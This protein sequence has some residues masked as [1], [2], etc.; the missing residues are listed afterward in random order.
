MPMAQVEEGWDTAVLHG[1]SW[2]K[3]EWLNLWQ[4]QGNCRF[5]GERP[6]KRP[7]SQRV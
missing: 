3:R 1:L 2:L 7:L 4:K 5:T 6:R